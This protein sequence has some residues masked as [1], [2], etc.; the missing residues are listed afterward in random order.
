MFKTLRET[1]NIIAYMS[2]CLKL[3]AKLKILITYRSLCSKLEAKL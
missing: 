2:L 3:E 1:L